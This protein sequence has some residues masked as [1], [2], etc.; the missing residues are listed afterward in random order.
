MKK[1]IFSARFIVPMLLCSCAGT[2][3]TP[4]ITLQPTLTSA[5]AIGICAFI[6]GLLLGV[7]IVRNI[8]QK[9]RRRRVVLPSVAAAE[10]KPDAGTDTPVVYKAD[11]ELEEE[12]SRLRM[13]LSQ[14]QEDNAALQR[15]LQET[16]RLLQAGSPDCREI[17]VQAG[18]QSVRYFLQPTDGKFSEGSNVSDVAD[19]LYELNC[20]GAEA[21]FRFVDTPDNVQLAVQYESTRIF[22]AC[23]RSNMPDSHTHSIRTD[24]PGKAVLRGEDW[25]IVQK[26][27]ITYL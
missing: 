18:S 13:K 24:I 10:P 19:A 6:A 23:E 9:H 26:A 14:L 12:N 4:S 7:V 27:K 8:R 22:V 20:E 5:A 1:L 11:R 2:I 17:K 21:S 15:E 16:N 25:E 3:D